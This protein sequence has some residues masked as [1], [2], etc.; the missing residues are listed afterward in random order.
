MS[1]ATPSEVVEH[2][3]LA[4]KMVVA[5]LGAGTGAYCFALAD[6]IKQENIQGAT[7]YAV[8]VQKAMLERLRAD[9]THR[10]Y[11]GIETIWAD[12]EVPGGVKL[13]DRIC[14]A[15]IISNVL[16]QAES[17]EGLIKEAMRIL[18]AGGQMLVLDWTGSFG[19]MGPHPSQVVTAVVAKELFSKAG[20]AVAKEFEAGSHH[21]GLLLRKS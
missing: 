17:K 19:H 4:D 5:D 6:L 14:D 15:V 21:W 18:K 12:I 3:H 13:A 1:F 7:I 8:D 11:D 2:L 10:G 16:F 9:V 20:L